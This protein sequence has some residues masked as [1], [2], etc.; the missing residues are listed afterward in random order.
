MNRILNQQAVISELAKRTGWSKSH[1]E[2]FLDIFEEFVIDLINNATPGENTKATIF[3][4]FVVGGKK[5]E[6]R[7]V[8]DPRSGE[9]ILTNKSVVPYTK[10]TRSFRDKF[11]NESTEENECTND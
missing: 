9:Q 3:S 7:K 5:E 4:G 10:F 8:F 1:T 6:N 2:Y 11:K